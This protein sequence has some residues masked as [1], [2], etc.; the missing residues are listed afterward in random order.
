METVDQL[1]H[2]LTCPNLSAFSSELLSESHFKWNTFEHSILQVFKN[3]NKTI[4]QVTYKILCEILLENNGPLY[5]NQKSLSEYEERYNKQVFGWFESNRE[6]VSKAAAGWVRLVSIYKKIIELSEN[7]KYI[8]PKMDCSKR[9]FKQ[10]P[11]SIEFSIPAIFADTKTDSFD[12]LLI[13]PY[14]SKHPTAR[15]FSLYNYFVA[16]FLKQAK[17]D[18]TEILEISFDAESVSRDFQF[19]RYW[20]NDNVFKSAETFFESLENNRRPNIHYCPSCPMSSKCTS[21]MI[22]RKVHA[23]PKYETDISS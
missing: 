2:Y 4:A 19:N 20:V 1:G 23:T 15:S 11:I 10:D 17:I 5:K 18:V 7:Y 9:I 6:M 22:L 3:Q 21:N 14:T 8:L 16:D 12:V 13:V